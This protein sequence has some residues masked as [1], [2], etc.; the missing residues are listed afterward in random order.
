MSCGIADV[1]ID[2]ELVEYR[3]RK[4]LG[5]DVGILQIC[6]HMNDMY[7]TERH[8]FTNKVYVYL[9]M[10]CPSMMNRVVG[11]VH[12]KH[13]VTVDDS[14]L[15]NIDIELLKK[16]AQLVT[17]GRGIGDATVL[18]FSARMGNHHLPLGG[19]GY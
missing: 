19:P 16:I 12:N 3:L 7:L 6:G 5:H 14:S 18:C 13:I 10:L 9:N 4:S 2:L 15:Q 11:E 1:K 17:L 8:Q